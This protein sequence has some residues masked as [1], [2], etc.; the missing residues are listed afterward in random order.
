[1]TAKDIL[2]HTI[3]M[4]NDVI[5]AYLGDLTD[6]ELKIRS[7]PGS[8]HLAWQLGHLVSSERKLMT[9]A[10]FDMPA[11][12]DGFAESYTPE[13]SSSDDADKFHK[14]EEYLRLM[15]EQRAATLALLE[16]ASDADFDKA[17]PETMHSHAKNVGSL[18]NLIGIHVLMHAGQFVAVRRKLQKP[19]TI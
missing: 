13:T 3:N 1:M 11:L 10:G 2:K 19:I 17:T 8:N 4:A 16:K 15:A 6:D 18:F 9:D 7:S 12:P 14:K 5:M